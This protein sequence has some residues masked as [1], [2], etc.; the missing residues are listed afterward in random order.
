MEMIKEYAEL[1]AT[2]RNSRLFERFAQFFVNDRA[3]TGTHISY[4]SCQFIYYQAAAVSNAKYFF[5]SSL[6]YQEHSRV[7]MKQQSTL[8]KL[9]NERRSTQTSHLQKLLM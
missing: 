5:S 1:R 4:Q 8:L 2:M 9:R 3:I 7:K 6:K